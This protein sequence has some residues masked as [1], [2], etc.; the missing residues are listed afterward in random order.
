MLKTCTACASIFTRH[1]LLSNAVRLARL[2]IPPATIA[3]NSH[4]LMS[5]QVAVRL[6]TITAASHAVNLAE[7]VAPVQAALSHHTIQLQQLS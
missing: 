6:H 2:V 1:R 5:V 3:V 4:T 7:F